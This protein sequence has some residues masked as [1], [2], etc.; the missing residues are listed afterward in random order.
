M[1]MPSAP[2]FEN[3]SYPCRNIIRASDPTD[4]V[5]DLTYADRGKRVVWKGIGVE[6]NAYLF[7]AKYYDGLTVEIQVDPEF[8]LETARTLAETYG[9]LLGQ[10]PSGLRSGIRS[11]P[12]LAGN[13]NWGGEN[14]VVTIRAG[15]T[16]KAA[17]G[18]TGSDRLDMAGVTLMHEAVHASLDL[19]YVFTPA[20]DYALSPEWTAAQQADDAFI[21]I[22]ARDNPVREDLAESYVAYVAVR[23]RSARISP[24]D[25]DKIMRTIPNRIA[26]LDARPLAMD[27]II[28][29]PPPLK[30]VKAKASSELTEP[31]NGKPQTA[32]RLIEGPNNGAWFWNSDNQG[33]D[34][35]P[36]FSLELEQRSVVDG[37]YI[38]W[39]RD[40]GNIDPRPMKYKVL[41]STDGTSW[42]ETGV[43][44][45]CVRGLSPD[46]GAEMLPGWSSPTQFI[47]VE[48]SES[49]YGDAPNNNYICCHYVLVTGKPA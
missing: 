30:L 15:R 2:P 36:W 48:M 19:K 7:N 22:Y 6:I 26:F 41:S 32:E 5:N 31:Y 18:D 44:Q 43:D 10:L 8:D 23:Y 4:F 21:S 42:S 39:K 49:S 28:Q 45:S 34:P 40:Y 25:V 20:P 12:I 37:L 17:E 11:M 27:P 9:K 16:Y 35:K 3:T 1:V 14:G 13:D 38:R 33:R 29:L 46:F 24:T 47:K